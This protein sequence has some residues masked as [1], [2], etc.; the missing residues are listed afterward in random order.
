[1]ASKVAVKR[2]TKEYRAIV[3][4]PPPYIT[5]KPLESNIL[6][7]HYVLRGPHDTPYEG[8]EYH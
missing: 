8:G 5:A 7:W 6:E 3:Q 1:M 2:L 4:S